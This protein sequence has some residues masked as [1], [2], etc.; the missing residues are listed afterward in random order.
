LTITLLSIAAVSAVGVASSAMWRQGASHRFGH[1]W[2]WAVGF[3]MFGFVTVVVL[4]L[5]LTPPTLLGTE[6]LQSSGESTMF[7]MFI[8]ILKT[9]VLPLLAVAVSSFVLGLGG[10]CCWR[11]TAC[12]FTETM[13]CPFY[14]CG[15][16]AT[17]CSGTIALAVMIVSIGVLVCAYRLRPCHPSFMSIGLLA[18]F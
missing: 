14:T 6:M 9:F 15:G 17:C 12:V 5:T 2:A 13:F 10:A 7:D 3:F 4:A 8:F 11:C 1:D 16:L 18:S